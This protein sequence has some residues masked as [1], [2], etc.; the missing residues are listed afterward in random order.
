VTAGRGSLALLI[1]G[2][3]IGLSLTNGSAASL[4]LTSTALTSLRTCTLT[5]TPTTTAVVLDTTVRQGTPNINYGATTTLRVSSGTAV[6][7][8]TYVRFDLGQCNPAIPAGATIRLATLRLYASSMTSVCRT[9]DLFRV[10]TAWTESTIT[11][12]NQPF[13]TAL[14]NPPSSQ[15]SG[16]FTVG[17]PVSCQNRTTGTYIIGATVTGDVAAFIT[18]ATTNYGWMLRDDVE[19]SSTARTEVFSAKELAVA[20][21]AP[22]LV[23]SYVTTP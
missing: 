20:A 8:R 15:R 1:A 17:T 7:Q 9:V 2:L 11:W 10:T 13:G 4:T 19:N 5:G 14:N 23:V 22:Q 3:L 12:N 21:Q 18:G 16:V 6:N